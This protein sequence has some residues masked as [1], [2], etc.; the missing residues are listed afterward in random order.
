M[1]E[2]DDAGDGSARHGCALA[3]VAKKMIVKSKRRFVRVVIPS[4]SEVMHEGKTTLSL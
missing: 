4:P 2:L 3:I 1:R